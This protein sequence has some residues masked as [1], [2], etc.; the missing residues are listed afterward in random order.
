MEHRMLSQWGS[1]WSLGCQSILY[2]LRAT[3]RLFVRRQNV[4][5]HVSAETAEAVGYF[6]PPQPQ[7]VWVTASTTASSWAYGTQWV[8]SNLLKAGCSAVSVLAV[9]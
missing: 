5:Y 2:N 6:H 8:D 1:R 7:P 3:C 9:Q 4:F